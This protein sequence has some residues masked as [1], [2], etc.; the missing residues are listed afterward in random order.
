M[1]K[2]SRKRMKTRRT[3]SFL[4]AILLLGAGL[5]LIGITNPLIGHHSWRQA[6]TAAMARNF[7]EE[8]FDILY[9][10]VD[11]RGVTS[12]EVECEFPVYQFIVASL[13]RLLGVHES[14][15]RLLSVFFSLMTI[16]GMYLLSKHV[17]S[18]I[19][20]LWSAF[21]LAVMPMPIFFGRTFMPEALL[22]GTCTFSILLFMKWTESGSLLSL[23]MSALLLT[24]ACL[25]K[26]PSLYL[27]LPLAYMAY[28]RYKLKAAIRP[29]LW[30]YAILIFT[31]L[32]LWYSHAHRIQ[33]DTGLTF[34]IWEYGSD[35]WGNWSLV[36]SWEF[37]KT[38]FFQR[39]PHK[40]LSYLG[41]PILVV[42]LARKPHSSEEKV[43]TLWLAGMLV[44]V[45]IV[46]RGVYV[47]DYYILP[48][49]IPT[50]YF[51]GKATAWGLSLKHP[52]PRWIQIS[53]ALC[54]LGT[55]IVSL[56]TYG[57]LLQKEKPSHST[58][59]QLAQTA[60]QA[61]PENSLVVAVDQGDP[62]LLYY[63]H[64]KGW[65]SSPQD[66]K[67]SWTNARIN[68]GAKYILGVQKD[69]EAHNAVHHLI[70]L[71]G[72]YET[73]VNSGDFF[74]VETNKMREAAR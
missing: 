59:F 35:K 4:C 43:F 37:W 58:V 21:F 36:C 46:G 9:P 48:A 27:G 73:V 11:W 30:I 67:K 24:V 3:A 52:P 60:R 47:H 23:L 34:G 14:I 41:L 56:S 16:V 71:L 57:K 6:D 40:I 1:R 53:V 31:A 26:P 20:G 17:A 65:K 54:L 50:S 28:R 12:G 70:Y 5:R 72:R 19:V 66:L 38:I 69:F 68:Q 44:F 25:L 15:G 18:P 7:V 64:M 45:V 63:S 74:I 13:Y 32:V 42:G 33:Q 55:V 29:E 10:R 2:E 22:L 62:M 8:E 49:V 51:L 39:I 61:L